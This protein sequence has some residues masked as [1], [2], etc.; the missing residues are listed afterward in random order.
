MMTS[1]AG[2]ATPMT[3]PKEMRMVATAKLAFSIPIMSITIALERPPTVNIGS[4]S[5]DT[6][7]PRAVMSTAEHKMTTGDHE[8]G[9]DGEG[10]A[11]SLRF[12]AAHW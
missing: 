4:M 5:M 8:N 6:S 12:G 2:P 11:T 10:A 7:T 3:P 9:G 1:W